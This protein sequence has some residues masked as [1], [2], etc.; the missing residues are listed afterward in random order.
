M[1]SPITHSSRRRFLQYLAASPLV[2]AGSIETQGVE[3]LSKLPDPMI[4]APKV[5]ELIKG[6]KEAINVFDFE[7]VARKN[8]PPAHFGYMASG[9]DDEVTLRANREGFLKFQLRPR[10]LNDVSKIDMGVELF[11]AKYDSPIIVCPTG[12]NKFFHQDG[13]TAVAKAARAGNHLQI[14]FNCL[15][16]LGGG[17]HQGARSSCL[18]PA[19]CI[20]AVGSC[21]GIDQARGG[22]WLPGACRY[23]RSRGRSQPGNAFPPYA[24][25]HARVFRL[26]RPRQLCQTIG[27]ATQ[28]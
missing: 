12:G 16:R 27:A 19:I 7:P 24:R 5:G 14:L 6:P 28:L 17:R 18:V 10:R 11:G 8:V 1:T 9:I 21:S 2:A 13:E 15:E 22:S 20:T 3:T 25:G 26:S 4:W 23:G